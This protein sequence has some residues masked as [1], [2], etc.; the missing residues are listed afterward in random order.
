MRLPN[1]DAIKQSP[2]SLMTDFISIDIL[3]KEL[4]DILF[5]K[6]KELVVDK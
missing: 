5:S 6:I 2:E 3:Q 4:I 1:S